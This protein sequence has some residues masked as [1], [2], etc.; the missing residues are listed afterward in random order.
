[1]LSKLSSIGRSGTT[2]NMATPSPCPPINPFG[3]ISNGGPSRRSDRTANMTTAS[4]SPPEELLGVI[5]DGRPGHRRD[6]ATR[7]LSPQTNTFGVI[8]DG[9]PSR[10]SIMHDLGPRPRR[11]LLPEQHEP[12]AAPPPPP[13][14]Q[15]VDDVDGPNDG[16][17]LDDDE[18]IPSPR[19]RPV[20]IAPVVLPLRSRAP[21]MD[22]I[23]IPRVSPHY[24]RLEPLPPP[25]TLPIPHP[26]VRRP[27]FFTAAPLPHQ[28]RL[29]SA[30]PARGG[31]PLRPRIHSGMIL[32]PEEQNAFE[33][34]KLAYRERA[35]A[36]A[37]MPT[38]M[39]TPRMPERRNAS[40]VKRS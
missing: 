33:A 9:E 24:P 28:Q 29:P 25:P 3:V 5:G 39:P 15:P 26:P 8:G 38:P 12:V 10:R 27:P 11:V 7:P 21:I 37:S 31:S 34:R 35:A 23:T 40:P 13:R 6:A 1:M 32:R 4:A 14:P 36:I 22:G 20:T 17:S 2:V 30:G 19:I 16:W 18:M